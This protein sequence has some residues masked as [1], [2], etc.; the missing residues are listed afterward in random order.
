MALPGAGTTTVLGRQR[1][2]W[3]VPWSHTMIGPESTRS[4]VGR[5]LR[6]RGVA[7][8]VRPSRNDL[9]IAWLPPYGDPEVAILGEAATYAA[10][11]AATVAALDRLTD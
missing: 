9:E 8:L 5:Y 10:V 3:W 11:G 1:Y 4:S 2:V 7:P 6:R